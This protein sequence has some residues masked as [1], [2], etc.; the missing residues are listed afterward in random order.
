MQLY[1][2]VTVNLQRTQTLK[3]IDNYLINYISTNK[4]ETN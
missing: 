4:S 3:L 2:K 1:N